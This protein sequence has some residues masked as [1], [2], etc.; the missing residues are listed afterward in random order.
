MAKD[1]F[2]LNISI[3]QYNPDELSDTEKVWVNEAIE[4]AKQAYAPYSG[5]QVGA[6]VIL[7]DGQIV[8]GSNQENAAYPSGICAERVALF[9]AGAKYPDLP[10]KAI[11]IAACR[12]GIIQQPTAPCGACR[13]VMLETEMRYRNQLRIILY[14]SD[15]VYEA[16]SAEVL[17]PLA[18][19]NTF[20][21]K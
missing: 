8:T 21:N 17:L 10:V 9:Y 11:V 13:Q 7:A 12:D 16:S 2:S 6:A 5:F 4:A 14:G 3:Q 19:N 18:F 1:T 15:I 20:I